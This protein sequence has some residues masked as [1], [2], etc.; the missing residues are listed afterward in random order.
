VSAQLSALFGKGTSMGKVILDMSMSLDGFIAGVDGADVGLYNWYFAPA[1]ADPS[2]NSAFVIQELIDMLGAIIMG[3]NT[4][5]TG[6]EQGGFEDSPYSAVNVLLTHHPPEQMPQGFLAADSIESALGQARAAAGARDIAIG[7]GANVAQQY[8]RTGLVDEIQI[9]LVP[10]L[11]GKG[12]RLFDPSAAPNVQLR[13]TRVLE[14]AGVT[15]I[16]YDVVK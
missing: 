3:R 12:L 10:I 1:D 14:A 2:G 15:H 11:V 9:H 8:L 13:I 4:F 6:D 16:R 5:R 7:G